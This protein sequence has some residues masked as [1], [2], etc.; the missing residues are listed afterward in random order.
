MQL[1]LTREEARVIDLA[2]EYIKRHKDVAL[3]IYPA[4]EDAIKTIN[5][6]EGIL[7][8]AYLRE[9]QKA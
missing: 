2:F 4:Y 7:R 8:A 9:Q 1:E 3:K 5:A 6:V